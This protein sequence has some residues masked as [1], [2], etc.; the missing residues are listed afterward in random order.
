[1]NEQK[2]SVLGT[3]QR[4]PLCHFDDG[5]KKIYVIMESLSKKDEDNIEELIAHKRHIYFKNNFGEIIDENN[6]LSY[7]EI[8]L[9]K[10][11]DIE[12]IK[13]LKVVN[14]DCGNW[15]P[16]TF[17]YDDATIIAQDGIV[18]QYPTFNPVLN[19]KYCHCRL[20]KPNRIIIY[21]IVK[22]AKK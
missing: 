18:K 8:N 1:M 15:V 10:K 17:N 20:G 2:I 7:G 22:R 12:F 11:S 5:G 16:S 3:L 6:I 13:N 19:F 9:N 4:V 14:Q 21:N